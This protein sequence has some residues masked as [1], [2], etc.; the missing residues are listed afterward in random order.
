MCETTT[1][2]LA[3]FAKE[4]ALLEWATL[5]QRPTFPNN[6]DLILKYFI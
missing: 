6:M 5:V 2:E 4:I 1:V 3:R